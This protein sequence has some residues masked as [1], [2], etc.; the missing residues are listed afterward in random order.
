MDRGFTLNKQAKTAF[1]WG[2]KIMMAIKCIYS[3]ITRLTVLSENDATTIF[4]STLN[5]LT[6]LDGFYFRSW[7]LRFCTLLI[8]NGQTA[9]S[10]PCMV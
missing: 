7:R 5:N 3:S 4:P 9:Q 6:R 1:K 10:D 8:F 2:W